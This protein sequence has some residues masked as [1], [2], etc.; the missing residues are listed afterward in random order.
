M[1]N[2]GLPELALVGLIC[3]FTMVPIVVVAVVLVRS[4]K[5]SR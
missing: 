3:A 5:R 1:L 4:K 2:I